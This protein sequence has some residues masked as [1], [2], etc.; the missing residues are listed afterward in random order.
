MKTLASLC[1]WHDL[2]SGL[3]LMRHILAGS[4]IPSGQ[5]SDGLP[6]KGCLN[7]HLSLVLPHFAEFA[8]AELVVG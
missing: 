1:H 8:A 4:L 6:R 2:A 7:T 3:V 5:C